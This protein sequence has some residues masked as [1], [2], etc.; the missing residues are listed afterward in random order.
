M[1]LLLIYGF[2]ELSDDQGY[3]LYALNLLLCPYELS[4]ETPASRQQSYNLAD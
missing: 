1:I 2:H 4:F 3:A